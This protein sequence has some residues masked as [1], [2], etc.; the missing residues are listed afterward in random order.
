MWNGSFSSTQLGSSKILARELATPLFLGAPPPPGRK[1]SRYGTIL[2]LTYQCFLKIPGSKCHEKKKLISMNENKTLS[3]PNFIVAKSQY[4]T[5]FLLACWSMAI[6]KAWT[7]LVHYWLIYKLVILL[8]QLKTLCPVSACRQPLS[9]P[10]WTTM[11]DFMC[12]ISF[13]HVFSKESIKIVLLP[14]N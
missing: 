5:S 14:W 3:N 2:F 12:S 6:A 1:I 4:T 11:I 9:I 10:L 7:N 8:A 13:G